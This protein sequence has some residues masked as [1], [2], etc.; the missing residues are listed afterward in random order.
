VLIAGWKV[1]AADGGGVHEPRW[2]VAGIDSAANPLTE[3]EIAQV[4]ALAA[5]AWGDVEAG[6]FDDYAASLLWETKL[7][8]RGVEMKVPA[9]K[10]LAVLDGLVA[11]LERKAQR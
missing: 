8:R 1:G 7:S 5:S 11:I 9:G 6:T 10:V 2:V 3:A 4:L